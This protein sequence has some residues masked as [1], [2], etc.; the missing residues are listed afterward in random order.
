MHL[1]RQNG[2]YAGMHEPGV[3]KKNSRCGYQECK[4]LGSGWIEFTATEESKCPAGLEEKQVEVL[5]GTGAGPK[6]RARKGRCWNWHSYLHHSGVICYYRL[7]GQEEDLVICPNAGRIKACLKCGH[8]KPH[9]KHALTCDTYNST[10]KHC[11]P[12]VPYEEKKKEEAK[13]MPAW[14]FSEKEDTVRFLARLVEDSA[15]TAGL[16][17]AARLIN[18]P[19][20]LRGMVEGLRQNPS[21]S[22]WLDE[23]GYVFEWEKKKVV[24]KYGNRYTRPGC[25]RVFLLCRVAQNMVCLVVVKGGDRWDNAISVADVEN[26]NDKEWLRITGG[27]PFT[28]IEDE[29]DV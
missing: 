1:M 6:L 12:C 26:L 27:T 21:Y 5:L 23:K 2:E 20:G 18:H 11:D 22:K 13:I 9:K 14:T 25:D 10:W 15:C 28:L 3:H 29:N 7:V 17:A 24:H 8:S 4:D 19:D 16:A